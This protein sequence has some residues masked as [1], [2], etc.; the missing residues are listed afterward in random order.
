MKRINL[1]FMIAIFSSTMFAQDEGKLSVAEKSEII[2]YLEESWNHLEQSISEITIAQWSYKPADTIWSI[3][4][5]SEHLEKSEAQL[6]ALVNTNLMSSP[7]A[8]EKASE[9]SAKTPSVLDAITSREHKVKTS[10]D[11]EPSGK[12]ATPGDF[13]QSFQKL[14]QQTIGYAQ[15]TEDTLRHH[16][17][18][19]GPL[20]D[21]DGY[22]ILMFMSG[23]LERHTQQIE[24]VKGDP[25]FPPA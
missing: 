24:E 21:L 16:F 13:L 5:I 12:Y 1:I 14:R 19:F 8:P 2:E 25:N 10:P 22:Q 18:P 11:L 20:G 15:N 23:H 4:E 6:F 3:S 7:A 9:V 17:V